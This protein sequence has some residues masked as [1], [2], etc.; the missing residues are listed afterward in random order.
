MV[1]TGP[2][3]FLGLVGLYQGFRYA[4]R[5]SGLK[6][7]VSFVVALTLAVFAG[8]EILRILA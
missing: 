3:F 7:P 2:L 1:L 6:L 8:E 4:S 5:L